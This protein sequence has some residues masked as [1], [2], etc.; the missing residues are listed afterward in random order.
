MASTESASSPSSG[1]LSSGMGWKSW[2]SLTVPTASTSW[3]SGVTIQRRTRTRPATVMA[4]RPTRLKAR[5]TASRPNAW[6]SWDRNELATALTWA[7]TAA[8]RWRLTAE[9]GPPGATL[10]QRHGLVVVPALLG[11]DLHL[12]LDL[13][14]L[15]GLAPGR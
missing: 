9:Q 7:S 6:R 14:G 13:P 11:L 10:H 8:S 2:P 5:T 15:V 12:G 3:L 1:E 4:T